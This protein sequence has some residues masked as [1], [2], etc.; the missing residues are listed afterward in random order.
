[1]VQNR[2]KFPYASLFLSLFLVVGIYF[3]ITAS[4]GESLYTAVTR[5]TQAGNTAVT[6]IF[7]NEVYPE[8]QQD[9]QLSEDSRLAKAVLTED[10]LRR[11]DKRVRGF[12]FGTDILKAKIYNINGITTYSSQFSQ[13]GENKKGTI[14]FDSAVEGKPTSQ[15]TRRG[16]F[17]ALDGDV[18]ERDLVASY[19]PINDKNDTL[20][21]VA[22]IYT[23]RSN[24]IRYANDLILSVKTK[25]IPLLAGTLFAIALIIWR[26]TS[27]ITQLKIQR[28]YSEDEQ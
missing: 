22:E 10:E 16:Q 6:R 5:T 17:S 12:M 18:F 26:F 8:L 4:V 14:G 2:L 25:L 23:D 19:I 24:T 1:M 3:I 27:L 28:E 15:V 7:I 21:G 9:L 11:V 13:I 20:I